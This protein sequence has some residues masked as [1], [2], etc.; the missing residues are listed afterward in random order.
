MWRSNK[1]H[2][3]EV[4]IY[5][6]EDP[7]DLE[8]GKAIRE[9]TTP[10]TVRIFPIKEGTMFFHDGEGRFAGEGFKFQISKK[11]ASELSFTIESGRTFIV[12]NGNTYRILQVLD[13]THVRQIRLMQCKSVKI[14][15]VD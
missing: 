2:E 15:N 13:Y 7:T 4:S 14:L 6:E 12:Y 11:Q 1:W 10:K 5:N 3:V 8:G 9:I